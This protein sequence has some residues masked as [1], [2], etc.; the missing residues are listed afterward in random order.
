MNHFTVSSLIDASGVHLNQKPC[1]TMNHFLSLKTTSY[2]S[3]CCTFLLLFLAS[4]SFAQS[5][6]SYKVSGYVF[7]MKDKKSKADTYVIAYCVERNKENEIISYQSG[8]EGSFFVTEVD[9]R[10]TLQLSGNHE[11]MVEFVKDGFLMET[12]SFKKKDMVAGEHIR[13]EIPL[14]KGNSILLSEVFIDEDTGEPLT[15][16]EVELRNP[17][18]QIVKKVY[19]NQEGKYFISIPKEGKYTLGGCKKSYFHSGFETLHVNLKNYKTYKR[20]IPIQKITIGYKV[21]L[22]DL[23]YNINDTAITKSGQSVLNQLLVVL[24]NNPDI[25]IE[26]GCH[27]DSRGDDDYNMTLSENRAK[28]AINYLINNGIPAKRLKAKGYGES[29]LINQCKN[30]VKCDA[31]KHE[32]NRRVEYTILSV[33]DEG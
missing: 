32:E 16:V 25:I 27:T 30:G 3:W 8:G 1:V 17:T 26:L 11:Y 6:N 28:S 15:N 2:R 20:E 22:G 19:T 23:Y 29:E 9:G 5:P 31:D 21:K 12:F 24:Q 10:F 13:I 4:P 33:G 18:N 14:R 7:G